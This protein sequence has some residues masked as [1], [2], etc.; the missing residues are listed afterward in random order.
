M[1]EPPHKPPHLTSGTFRT[2]V[3]RYPSR[4]L[5][6]LL[7]AAGLC[8][9]CQTAVGNYFANRGRD[10]TE[11]F[12]FQA[13]L[14][15]GLD[16]HV[17]ATGLAHLDVGTGVY[18]PFPTSFGILYGEVRPSSATGLEGPFDAEV[19]I[20]LSMLR[21]GRLHRSSMPRE[22]HFGSD[23]ACYA[24]LPAVFSW[25]D[26]YPLVLKPDDP[27][28]RW[29][30]DTAPIMEEADDRAPVEEPPPYGVHRDVSEYER[31]QRWSRVHAFDI[32]VGAFALILGFKAG[33]SPGEFVDFLLGWFGVDIAG[34]DRPLEPEE[35]PTP[36]S[37]ESGKEAPG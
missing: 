31:Y 36:E 4:L 21:N 26:S 27:E 19:G 22:T 11:S 30:W 20:P 29:L 25:I 15:V 13:G 12:A 2:N 35:A 32:E 16:V 33:F 14:G 6:P 34:D 37:D 18:L 10:F 7:L 5:I 3:T 8:T 28:T 23:H 1:R 24:L 9:G 17:K